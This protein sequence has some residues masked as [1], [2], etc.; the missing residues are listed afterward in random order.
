[1]IDWM[2]NRSVY[3][4]FTFFLLSGLTAIVY[5][6]NILIKISGSLSPFELRALQ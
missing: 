5:K 1:M 2:T 4:D 6:S 3:E